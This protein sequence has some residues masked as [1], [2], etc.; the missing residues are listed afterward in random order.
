MRFKTQ[1]RQ[2][3]NNNNNDKDDGH[4]VLLLL[5]LYVLERKVDN[6]M[7]IGWAP[8]RVYLIWF[9]RIHCNIEIEKESTYVFDNV[10]WRWFYNNGVWIYN[11]IYYHITEEEYRE[12]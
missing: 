12:Y 8:R 1:R 4:T 2:N 9:H 10:L 5:L 6:S 11:I 7:P 3:P